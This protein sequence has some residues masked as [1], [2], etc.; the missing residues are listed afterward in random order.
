VWRFSLTGLFQSAAAAEDNRLFL[1]QPYQPGCVPIVF[2][3]GTASS[4]A[5]WADL[6][7]SLLREP[8][9]RRGAQFW[10][11]RYATGSPVL[12]SAADLRAALLAAVAEL[13]PEGRDPA[14]RHMVLVGHSQGG[15]LA[16]L[17]LVD[18]E[19]GWFERLAQRPLEDFDF[20]ARDRELLTRCLDFDPL[21]FVER[22]VY[23]AT[24]HAGSFLA[25]RWY[26]GLIAGLIELPREVVALGRHVVSGLG[27]GAPFRRAP[28]S[29]ENMDPDDRVLALLRATPNA[30]DVREHSII[31]IGTAD[32]RDP[33]AVA[34]ADDGVVAYASAHLARA[35]SEDLVPSSHSCQ[36]HPATIRALRRILLEH[37]R[38]DRADRGDA[39]GAEA[40]GDGS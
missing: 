10:F 16:R 1:A 22:V 29:L 21:P 18:G 38:E 36:S 34:A 4:P 35:A 20:D 40:R 24:P 28:T 15:L 33:A 6:F 5:Y 25:R 30:R 27:R 2:V 13:D 11:F 37:L 7:N 3:H 26:S 31:A 12:Y 19:L 17:M 32:P 39:E 9:L 8:E 23:V 14:L